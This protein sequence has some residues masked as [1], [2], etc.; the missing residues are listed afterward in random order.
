MMPVSA[1]ICSASLGF[2]SI[3]T[4]MALA[5]LERM[6][7]VRSLSCFAVG[8]SPVPTPGM[9]VPTTE[10]PYR[11]AKYPWL[12]W[13]ITS[14]RFAAGTSATWLSIQASSSSSCAM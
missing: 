3:S 6:A 2:S 13:F 5:P 4:K 11:S 9:T 14:L 10:K 12:A 8:V 1:A 7:A